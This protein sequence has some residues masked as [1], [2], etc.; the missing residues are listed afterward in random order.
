MWHWLTGWFGRM[1]QTFPYQYKSA[2]EQILPHPL[3]TLPVQTEQYG[4]LQ[5]NFLVDSGADV[6]IL[7]LKPYASLFGFQ[8]GNQ[9]V[10]IKG[11]GR[12]LKG[13]P[14][15]LH[16]RLFNHWHHIACYLVNTST[17][18]LLGR[19]DVWQLASIKFNNLTGH[20]ILEQI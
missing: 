3:I 10:Q 7:P 11:I 15:H 5:I 12:T 2:S 16:L 17:L 1:R 18:P 13:Y 6:T 14:Y 8:P 20:T 4:Q 19:Q 9:F